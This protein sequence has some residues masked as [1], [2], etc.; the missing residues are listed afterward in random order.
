M[1]L[2]ALLHVRY[3]GERV[4]LSSRRVRLYVLGQSS[5]SSTSTYLHKALL[6]TPHE[7][8]TVHTH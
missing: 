3:A 8:H 2:R 4:T 1:A 6:A 7:T 5:C